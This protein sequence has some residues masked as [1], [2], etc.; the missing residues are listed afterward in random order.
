M[1]N[2]TPIVNVKQFLRN[3]K[4]STRSLQGNHFSYTKDWFQK[5]IASN[6]GV[7]FTPSKRIFCLGLF[8]L[9]CIYCSSYSL[10]FELYSSS[11]IRR[12]DWLYFQSP[13]V[14]DHFV[15]DWQY[16]F[17]EPL[18]VREPDIQHPQPK[19]VENTLSHLD[20]YDTI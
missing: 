18:L 7:F 4:I 14:L 3:P 6:I 13:P 2:C 17:F 11:L 16:I 10:G 5:Q 19:Q 20:S 12:G 1:G 8:V 15:L 9:H